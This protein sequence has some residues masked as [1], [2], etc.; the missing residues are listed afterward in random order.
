MS[1]EKKND[2]GS[3]TITGWRLKFYHDE[4]EEFSS[5]YATKLDEIEASNLFNLLQRQFTTIGDV[6]LVF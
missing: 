2:D 6:Q 1:Y 5:Q 4:H 3:I